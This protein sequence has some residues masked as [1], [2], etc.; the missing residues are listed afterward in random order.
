[1]MDYQSHTKQRKRAWLHY[2]QYRKLLIFKRVYPFIVTTDI[3]NFFDTVLHD[4]L[5]E[6]FHS[7]A[8]P[9]RMI[10]LLFFCWNASQYGK[11]S[12]I[13]RVLGYQWTNSIVLASLLTCFSTRT[14]IES[15]DGVCDAY[16]RW[17]DDQNIGVHTRAEGLETLRR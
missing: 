13:P 3:T 2:S 6:C 15:L 9:P 5:A 8:A 14:T 12:R 10:G 1:M 7:I 4:K 16:V 17:M 11:P